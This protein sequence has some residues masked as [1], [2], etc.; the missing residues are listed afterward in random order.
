MSE[1]KNEERY[2]GP[3]MRC[4]DVGDAVLDAIREDNE[5]KEVLVEEH[6]SY[7]RIKVRGQCLVRFDTVSDMLGSTVSRGEIESNMPAF[8]GF[9]RVEGDQMLFLAES[10]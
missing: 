1:S 10:K 2:V 5:D 4:G 6:A 8:E 7:M 3:V 9:I